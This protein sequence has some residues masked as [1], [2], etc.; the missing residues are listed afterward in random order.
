MEGQKAMSDTG[1]DKSQANLRNL[2][3]QYQPCCEVCGTYSQITKTIKAST[4]EESWR[5][6]EHHNRPTDFKGKT[7]GDEEL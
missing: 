1:N 6:S 2:T 7:N 4:K 5:C 3:K